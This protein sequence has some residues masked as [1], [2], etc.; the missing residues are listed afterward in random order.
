MDDLVK[1]LRCFDAGAY[2]TMDLLINSRKSGEYL[3]IA[4]WSENVSTEQTIRKKFPLEGDFQYAILLA[5]E[6]N[7]DATAIEIRDA[8]GK[9]LEYEY[10]I[11]D[12]DRNQINFFYTPPYSGAYFLAF[13]TVNTS[14]AAT[15]MYMT[16]MKGEKD[17]SEY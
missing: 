13:R 17:P 11:T 6:F 16:V 4:Q 14:K 1:D 2:T 10:K 8:Q 3:V 12:L 5:T 7:V 9:K 15:C